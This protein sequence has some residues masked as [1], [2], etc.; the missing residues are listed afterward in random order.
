MENTRRPRWFWLLFAAA[1]LLQLGL[2][3][4]VVFEKN[5]ILRNGTEFKIRTQPIDPADPFRGRYVAIDVTVPV[6]ERIQ[7]QGYLRRGYY[8]RLQAD[9]EGFAQV[10]A[11]SERPLDGAG[12]LHMRNAS[13]YGNTFIRLPYDRY[14]MQ[15]KLAPKAERA[16]FAR[17]GN[18]Y[19]TV[20]VKNGKGVVSGLYLDD[21]RVEDY[22]RAG[23]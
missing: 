5:D 16:Y 10:A 1:V 12:V 18:A 4:G 23:F 21:I 9:A 2:P 15:E 7:S 20:R 8:L 13:Y 3:L 17:Q 14:Y 11:I 22:V 6:P 19:V